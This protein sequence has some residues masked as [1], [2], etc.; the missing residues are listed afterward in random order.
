[1]F[2][3]IIQRLESRTQRSI[4]ETMSRVSTMTCGD[5]LK[6]RY[7]RDLLTNAA[8]DIVKLLK[9]EED[10][11]AKVIDKIKVRTTHRNLKRLK[12]DLVKLSDAIKADDPDDIT[13]SVN[14]NRN[15]TWGM[16]PS[17]V[18]SAG[19]EIK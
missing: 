7:T 10:L 6:T 3:N 14:W 19:S 12:A 16:N 15:R 18:V 5:V 11:P 4:D 9:P 2:E 17:V 8:F 13:I 1:M